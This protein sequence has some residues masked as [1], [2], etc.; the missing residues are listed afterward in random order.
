EAKRAL[1]SFNLC[2]AA[3]GVGLVS[4]ARRARLAASASTVDNMARE[5]KRNIGCSNLS[6]RWAPAAPPTRRRPAQKLMPALCVLNA[7]A[8]FLK[9]PHILDAFQGG[10][11][12]RIRR[13]ETVLAKQE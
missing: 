12:T 7:D 8:H 11:C 3:A 5:K 9:L 10:S 1:P 6:V 2:Q 4:W 13:T